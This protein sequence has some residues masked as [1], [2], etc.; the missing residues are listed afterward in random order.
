MSTATGTDSKASFAHSLKVLAGEEAPDHSVLMPEHL[1]HINDHIQ[2]NGPIKLKKKVAAT[3]T[4]T[5]N[6]KTV[7]DQVTKYCSLAALTAALDNKLSGMN[8]K[9]YDFVGFKAEVVMGAFM[10]IA[11]EDTWFEEA[12][13]L[14]YI[15][16]TRGNIVLQP[17]GNGKKARIEEEG[18]KRA[19]DLAQKFKISLQNAAARGALHPSTITFTRMVA[20]LPMVGAELL[21]RG[22]DGNGAAVRRVKDRHGWGVRDLPHAMQFPSFPGNIVE[23]YGN[24]VD[25][26]DITALTHAA[27]AYQ[28]CFLTTIGVFKKSTKEPD[29]I[30]QSTDGVMLAVGNMFVKADMSLEFLHHWGILAKGT[31]DEKKKQ[32]K[33]KNKKVEDIGNYYV[34]EAIRKSCC[35]LG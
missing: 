2:K 27:M 23:N 14:V 6:V 28:Y 24:N 8:L 16:V 1:D 30:T 15:G 10:T 4:V 17:V 9:V 31:E 3:N 29:A 12:V 20:C 33:K 25:A 22:A 32:G 21:H 35:C 13:E 5:I 34:I 26:N 18:E 11:G 7:T 19:V